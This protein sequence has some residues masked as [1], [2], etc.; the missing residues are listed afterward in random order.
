MKNYFFFISKTVFFAFCLLTTKPSTRG[1]RNT[2]LATSLRILSLCSSRF[3][4]KSVCEFDAS[5]L[6]IDIRTISAMMS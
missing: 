5:P 2:R 1:I 6:A 3:K 4:D